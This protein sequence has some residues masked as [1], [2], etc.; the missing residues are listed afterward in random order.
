MAYTLNIS[1]V[2]PTTFTNTANQGL[3]IN[4]SLSG[5]GLAY[6]GFYIDLYSTASG[7]SV[8]KTLYYEGMYDLVSGV[9]YM[10]SFA[11]VAPGTYYVS[12]YYKVQGSPRKAITVTAQSSGINNITLNGTKI[13]T[14]NLNNSKVLNETLNGNKV[15]E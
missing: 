15:Y 9:S 2:S 5:S 14:N 4:F 3:R 12:V 8:I 13:T 11:D 6:P 1:S 7:G 10:V